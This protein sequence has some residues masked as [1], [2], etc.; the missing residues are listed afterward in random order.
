LSLIALVG[1]GLFVRSLSQA[2]AI[3][4]GFEHEHTATMVIGSPRAGMSNAEVLAFRARMLEAARAIPGVEAASLADSG[5]FGGGLRRTTFI[6]GHERGDDGVLIDVN[7]VGSGYF[8]TLKIPLLEGRAFTVDDD[9]PDAEVV[10]INRTMAERYWPDSSPIGQQIRFQGS[11]KLL[12]V[13]GV[14]ADIKYQN[15]GEESPPYIYASAYARVAPQQILV[16]RFA[17]DPEAQLAAVQQTLRDAADGAPIFGV[18]TVEEILDGSLWAPRAAAILLAVFGG[19]ALLLSATGI[20]G[21]MNYNV[22]L[23]THEFGVRMALGAR[24]AVL[25]S[26]VLR[27]SMTLVMSGLAVGILGA[28]LLSRPVAP[29]LFEISPADPLAYLGALMILLAVALLASSFPARRATR[30]DPMEALRSE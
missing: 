19:L 22:N 4:P 6:V 28:L 15:L 11:D 29:M 10:V 1:S 25:R 23:R 14:A 12:T 24:P 18:T 21:L 26:M 13:A 9:D 20:Y 16:L 7:A 17:G 2:H 3:D 8:E 5:P 27:Q 30:V